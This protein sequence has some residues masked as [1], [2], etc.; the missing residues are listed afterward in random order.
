MNVNWCRTHN[1]EATHYG[2]H[3]LECA[4]NLPGI[5]FP[6]LVANVRIVTC[7]LCHKLVAA[8]KVRCPYCGCPKDGNQILTTP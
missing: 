5:M 3:G 7:A 8:D 6:C 1:R 2:P 4:P